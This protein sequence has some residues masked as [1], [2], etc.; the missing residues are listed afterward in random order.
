M[1]YKEAW[2]DLKEKLQ[3]GNKLFSDI[4]DADPENVIANMKLSTVQTVQE[5]MQ[6]IE[7]EIVDT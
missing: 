5:Y 4:K 1:N 6:D 7:K 2:D 3:D